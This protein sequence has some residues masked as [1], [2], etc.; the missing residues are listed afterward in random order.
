MKKG[1][2]KEYLDGTRR[3]GK[4]RFPIDKYLLSHLGDRWDKVHSEL[5]Q[6]FDRRTYAGYTFWKNVK[7]HVETECWVGAETG[8]IYARDNWRGGGRVT[9]F[10]VHPET[11][12]LMYQEWNPRTKPAKPTAE[13]VINDRCN[14]EKIEGIWYYTE[15][16]PSRF[17]RHGEGMSIYLKRQLNRKT[18]KCLGLINDTPEERRKKKYYTD[19][20]IGR[21]PY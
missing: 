5:S 11:G 16:E 12:I 20:V 9:G 8:D 18:L 4:Y 21:R 14:I 13:I 10:Y 7:W 17:A 6:E 1:V 3:H 15:Y 2:R 19:N